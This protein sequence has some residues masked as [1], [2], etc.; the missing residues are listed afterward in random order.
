MRS[1]EL[2]RTQ[3]SWF[4]FVNRARLGAGFN[5]I[6]DYDLA[7]APD[8]LQYLDLSGRDIYNSYI[9]PLLFELPDNMYSNAVVGPQQISDAY[10]C[11]P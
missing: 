3:V 1:G 10:D 7:S 5:G 6:Y 4:E 9:R 8:V 11:V 2:F